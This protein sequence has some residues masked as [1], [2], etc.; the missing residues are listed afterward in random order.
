MHP[1]REEKWRCFFAFAQMCKPY[2]RGERYPRN[3]GSA[4]KVRGRRRTAKHG[5]GLYARES[6]VPLEN[7]GKKR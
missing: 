3:N 1:L 7:E 2:A 4:K 6:F 5:A